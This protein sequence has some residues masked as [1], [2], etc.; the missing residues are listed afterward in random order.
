MMLA[1]GVRQCY[2][3]IRPG[4]SAR[5][6]SASA[7]LT[8]RTIR[9]ANLRT[10][11]LAANSS[12]LTVPEGRPHT[13]LQPAGM[14]LASEEAATIISPLA[15]KTKDRLNSD[16]SIAQIE[17]GPSWATSRTLTKT[18]V[19]SERSYARTARK[20]SRFPAPSTIPLA[21]TGKTAVIPPRA[22]RSSLRDYDRPLYGERHMIENF[23]ARIKQFR[24]VATRYEKT[25]RNFLARRPTRRQCRV[26]P[27]TTGPSKFRS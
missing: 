12:H 1:T 19:V 15:M 2:R 17:G 7:W 4:H 26:A 27:L 18:V 11:A 13:V 20:N 25:A 3:K 14:R 9:H 8:L 23:F 16:N 10:A 21:A 5:T 6:P 22:N 24:A